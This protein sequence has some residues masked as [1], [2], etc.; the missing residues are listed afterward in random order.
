VPFAVGLGVV[1]FQGEMAHVLDCIFFHEDGTDA[2]G[3]E[4]AKG[5][6]EGNERDV[7]RPVV[8]DDAFEHGTK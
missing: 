2:D 3:E 8:V 7:S 1:V 5:K 4:Y 6:P